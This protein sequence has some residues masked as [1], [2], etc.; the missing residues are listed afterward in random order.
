MSI[1]IT[2]PLGARQQLSLAGKKHVPHLVLLLADQGVLAVGAEPSVGSR[3]TSG[4]G[5]AIIAGRSAAHSGLPSS[6]HTAD[7]HRAAPA[8]LWTNERL[9]A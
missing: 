3:F 7:R 5:E 8:S 6:I 9:A 4:T 2:W 1:P